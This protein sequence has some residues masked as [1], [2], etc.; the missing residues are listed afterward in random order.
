MIAP[1]RRAAWF[2]HAALIT[3]V[4]AVSLGL[5][6]DFSDPP[7]YDGAGYA[8]LARSIAEGRGYREIDRPDSPRHAHFP[9]GYPLVL[10]AL[11]KITGV[12]A[13]SAHAFSFGC[14]LVAIGLS[15]Q[16]FRSW[17]RSNVAL[18]MGLT[19]AVNWKWARDGT[20]IQSEPLFLVLSQATV[21]VSIWV[22][23]CGGLWPSAVLGMLLG[24]TILTRHV[25]IALAAA[26]V[27][28]LVCQ[29]KRREALVIVAIG[30]L[31]IS[32]WIVWLAMVRTG[33][34]VGLV[35]TATLAS[36]ISANS[37]FYVRRL[38]DQIIGPVIEV[39]TVFRPR[40]KTA[41]TVVA[42][43]ASITIAGNWIRLIRNKRRRLAGLVPVFTLALLLAWP[44]TEAGRF[45]LPI[46][47]FLIVALVEGCAT[48]TSR[49]RGP[50]PRILAA[51]LILAISLPYSIYAIASKRS[52]AARRTNRDFDAACQ[53]IANQTQ[54]GPVLTRH[55]GEV[56]WATGRKA[57]SPDSGDITTL[58]SRYSV[59][60]L[61]I[62]DER[63]AN[64]SKSPLGRYVIENPERVEKTLKTDGPH[65]V[66][67]YRSR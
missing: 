48:M 20:G 44:F 30:V 54:P 12:S 41:A 31:V 51:G 61:L 45:L 64:A 11:W 42:L 60:F 67:V 62:D 28:D 66:Y 37:L 22:S 47:P 57:V 52:E 34:Q 49:L 55:P 18:L 17:F 19:L 53:W 26:V 59:A 2:A 13:F 43:I 6:A 21:L 40:A 16:I 24:A 65:P 27:F 58:I 7:R 9:P 15:W 25:A 1:S 23:R 38:L 5:N 33:T 3:L 36:T 63:F 32:P 29:Q 35:P 50:K 39:A 46:I 8:V 10:A 14:T 4:G 56:F